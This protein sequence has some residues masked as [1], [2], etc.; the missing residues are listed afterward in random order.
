[1]LL[2][3]GFA[4]AVD[5]ILQHRDYALALRLFDVL[6]DQPELFG[7]GLASGGLSARR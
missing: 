6:E 4:Q 3:P 5:E 7:L 1:L 2:G